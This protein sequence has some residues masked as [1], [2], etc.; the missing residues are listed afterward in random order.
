MDDIPINPNSLVWDDAM[1]GWF[2]KGMP[3]YQTKMNI[4][5]LAKANRI[6]PRE[7]NQII[8]RNT[9]VEIKSIGEFNKLIDDLI[10]DI[11]DF[12]NK[13]NEL[14]IWNE[15]TNKDIVDYKSYVFDFDIYNE[16]KQYQQALEEQPKEQQNEN[17]NGLDKDYYNETGL[18][19][20]ILLNNDGP[21]MIDNGADWK[22]SLKK[23]FEEYYQ[24]SDKLLGDYVKLDFNDVQ[25][26]YTF[27]M[28]MPRERFPFK[29][30]IINEFKNFVVE[31]KTNINIEK[32]DIVAVSRSNPRYPERVYFTVKGDIP[33]EM[34]QYFGSKR[35]FYS[36]PVLDTKILSL[37]Q[38]CMSWIP[39][40]QACLIFGHRQ[41]MGC[42]HIRRTLMQ[43]KKRIDNDI[44]LTRAEKEQQKKQVRV[45]CF[46]CHFC[47]D[48]WHIADNCR[49]EA[50]CINCNKNHPA[51]K[52]FKCEKLQEMGLEIYLYLEMYQLARSQ[53]KKAPRR[54]EQGERIQWSKPWKE[55][56][57]ILDALQLEE[58]NSLEDRI[59]QQRE[60]VLS[61][62]KNIAKL[63]KLR[64][65]ILFTKDENEIENIYN[66]IDEINLIDDASS[67]KFDE[68][69]EMNK[70]L[71][72]SKKAR[73]DE[74]DELIMDEDNENAFKSEIDESENN[75]A[76]SDDS[77]KGNAGENDGFE[78]L[79]AKHSNDMEVDNEQEQEYPTP[80]YI[81]NDQLQEQQQQ[82][83]VSQSQSQSQTQNSVVSGAAVVPFRQQQQ[84]QQ[85]QSQ[86]QNSVVSGTVVIPFE[87][88]QQ[89]QHQSRQSRSR[90][91]V[92]S[93][94][95][96][97][98]RK[99]KSKDKK[100]GKSK[101]KGN[102]VSEKGSNKNSSNSKDIQRADFNKSE[103]FIKGR[104]ATQRNFVK[105][106]IQAH[107]IQGAKLP[108]GGNNDNSN[109]RNEK[110]M[111]KIIGK[112]YERIIDRALEDDPDVANIE[113]GKF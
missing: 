35:Y 108:K 85:S 49:N 48:K 40:C 55:S 104:G 11:I 78:S 46:G 34:P 25:K 76:D 37:P 58:F 8:F 112:S 50:Y 75:N 26:T 113:K 6:K 81:P 45:G 74:I 17:G 28:Y 44:G 53:H 9:D 51:L 110:E 82:Q 98:A 109:I 20:R 77:M 2:H 92:P 30:G 15:L 88:Q 14:S 3:Q 95:E 60:A 52:D 1:G 22:N 100:Y 27:W 102:K 65:K 36:E 106:S 70:M 19:L 89:D 41:G 80:E 64:M 68:I 99:S 23:E 72:V 97:K 107:G 4:L 62:K 16:W 7:R 54:P 71:G 105:A 43:A 59:L 86:T 56:N 96:S 101:K 13:K 33:E 24:Q 21:F 39:Q 38:K 87:Q 29:P 42:P 32:S 103:R 69:M 18:I 66:V 47:S 5:K 91:S 111:E 84:Q 83:Q 93:K 94:I 63:A 31:S 67:E 10:D 79:H 57:S 73:N 90:Q 12:K 61:K